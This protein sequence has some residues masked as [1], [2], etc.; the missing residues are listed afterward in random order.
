MRLTEQ[1]AQQHYR[2]IVSQ[3]TPALPLLSQQQLAGYAPTSQSYL[4]IPILMGTS[5]GA[6]SSI[7]AQA[8][9]SNTPG[10]Q[11]SLPLAPQLTRTSSTSITS[12]SLSTTSQT[13]ATST[14][15]RLTGPRV[16]PGLQLPH[17]YPPTLPS[18]TVRRMSHPL[19]GGYSLPHASSLTR[20]SQS[21]T[22]S[23]RFPTA[24][25][26]TDSSALAHSAQPRTLSSI[27][28]N[29]SRTSTASSSAAVVVASSSLPSQHISPS[30]TIPTVSSQGLLH[31]TSFPRTRIS[32][33]STTKASPR[34]PILSS[35]EASR[36]QDSARGEGQTPSSTSNRSQTSTDQVVFP[37]GPGFI[38]LVRHPETVA[39]LNRRHSTVPS[40]SSSSSSSSGPPNTT[41]AAASYIQPH[42]SL[43]APQFRQSNNFSSAETSTVRSSEC[44]PSTC[45]SVATTVTSC[46]SGPRRARRD[47]TFGVATATTSTHTAF[48]RDTR[49]LI[50]GSVSSLT[51]TFGDT[52]YPSFGTA[53]PRSSVHVPSTSISFTSLT[54]ST[55]I[56]SPLR[57]SGNSMFRF[58][59][60]IFLKRGQIPS[61]KIQGGDPY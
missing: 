32:Q 51:R 61:T 26:R 16:P 33:P 29:S 8:R 59:F 21:V 48:T 56:S 6:V 52:P 13:G 27:A 30:S 9:P 1:F 60:R 4:G 31:L 24:T 50:T 19:Q 12:P 36:L 15:T 37:K 5:G 55:P 7:P 22:T 45:T 38:T 42:A 44:T 35:T 46:A 39:F 28:S 2:N 18:Q 53:F 34:I 54:D 57:T 10:R 40:S 23:A 17:S 47:S 41:S 20:S 49:R 58:Y 25:L 43:L 11:P 14:T 3:A